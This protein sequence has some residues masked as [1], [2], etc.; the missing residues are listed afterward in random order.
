MVVRR[1]WLVAVL[2]F[3]ASMKLFAANYG[4]CTAMNFGGHL[5]RQ[6]LLKKPLKRF[7]TFLHFQFGIYKLFIVY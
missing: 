1:W 2:V 4:I 3:T 6:V 5:L 7:F